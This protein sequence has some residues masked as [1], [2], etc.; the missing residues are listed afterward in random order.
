MKNLFTFLGLMAL[1]FFVSVSTGYGG[2]NSNL[3]SRSDAVENLTTTTT[4]GPNWYFQPT[5]PNHTLLIMPEASIYFGGASVQ[6]GDYIGVFYDSLGVLACAGY[7]QITLGIPNAI[8]VWGKESGVEN[9]FYTGEAFSFKAWDASTDTYYDMITVNYTPSGWLP[10]A[11]TFVNQGMSGIVSMFDQVVPAVSFTGLSSTYCESDA[12]VTLVGSPSGGTF[13]GPGITGNVFSPSQAG[14][15]SYAYVV[16]TYAPPSGYPNTYALN[17][18]IYETPVVSISGLDATYSVTAP[19]ETMVGD[20]AGGIFSGTGVTGSVFS[21]STAGV[22]THQISYLYTDNNGCPGVATETVQ[23]LDLPYVDFTGL[24]SNYCEDEGSVTLTGIPS[25]GYFSGTAV[26]GNIFFPAIAGDGNHSITY[27]YTDQYGISNSATHSTIIFEVPTVDLGPDKVICESNTDETYVVASWDITNS[28]LWSNG[29]TS[30]YIGVNIADTYIVTITDANGCTNSDDIVLTYKNS[31]LSI[32]GLASGYCF[33]ASPVTL[34]TSPS[35]GTLSGP[36]ISG[37]TFTAQDAGIG[38]HAVSYSGNFPSA[39]YSNYCL[40]TFTQQVEVYNVPPIGLPATTTYCT[41]GTVTLDPGTFQ[42]YAWNTGATTS[43]I[44]VSTPGNYSVSVTDASGCQNSGSVSVSEASLPTPDLGSDVTLCLGET[45]TLN[46]GSYSAYVWS[47]GET[48]SSI[49]VGVA[50]NYAVTVTDAN[51]CSGSDDMNLSYVTMNLTIGGLASDYCIDDGVVSLTGSPSGGVFSGPG[52]SGSTFDPSVAGAG[53]KEIVYSY[54]D[55]NNCSDQESVSTLVHDLPS[56]ILPA[57]ESYCAGGSVVLDPGAFQSYSWSTGETTQTITVSSVGTFSVTVSDAHGCQNSASVVVSE[58]ALPTPDLGPDQTICQGNSVT[59]DPGSFAIYHWISGETTSTI[60]VNTSGNYMVAVTDANGCTNTDNTNI[61]VASNPVVSFSGLAADYCANAAAAT[62][63]GVPSTGTFSGSGV[64][65]VNFDPSQAGTGQVLVTYTVIDANGCTGSDSQNTTVFAQPVIDFGNQNSFCEGDNLEL[66]GGTFSTYLW[67]TT[68]TSS[69]IFV[70]TADTYTLS[71]SDANGCINS[72][73]VVVTMNAAPTV[74]LGSDQD[75][76]EGQ[77]ISLSAGSY[78]SYLWS[79]TETTQSISA[80][81]SGNYALTVTDINGCVGADDMN[82]TVHANPVVSFTGLASAFCLNDVDATLSPTPTGG[83]FSGQGI[84]GS[85]FSP[86]NAGVGQWTITYTL[87]DNNGCSDTDTQNTEVYALPVIDFGNQT[88]FCEG[89]SL[90]LNGGVFTAYNWSNGASTQNIVV[91]AADTYSL[92]VTDGNG[93]QNSASVAVSTNTL[94]VVDLGVDQTICDGDSYP[95]DAGAFESYIWSTTETTQTIS[96]ST[97]ES[98]GVTVTDANGCEGSD[99]FVLALNPVYNTTDQATICDGDAYQFGT[100]TLTQAGIYT[101]VFTA[102][103]GCDSTVVLTLTVNPIYN[104]TDAAAICQ[105]DSYIFGTQTLTVGGIFTEVFQSVEGCD[106]TVVLTLTVNPVY[107]ESDQAEICEGDTYQFGT[108]ILSTA[109]SFTEV[110]QSVDGCDSTVTLTLTVNPIY[111]TTDEVT[112]CEGDTYQFGPHSLAVASTYS[113]TFQSVDGCDSTVTLTLNVNPVYSTTDAATIC[114]GDVFQFGTQTLSQAGTFTEVFQSADG[115]DSTVSLTLTVNPTYNTTNA[116]I[117]CDGDSYSFGTQILTQ[118][119]TYTE[120]FQTVEGC[121]STVILSLTVN[122][123][124]NTTDVAVIC[125]GGFYMFGGQMLTTAGTYTHTFQS[126]DGCDSTVTFTLI[127]NPTYNTTD[128]ATICEGDVFQFGT[129]SLTQAGNHT[130]VFQTVDGCDSTVTLTLTVHPVFNTTDAVSICAGDTYQFGNQSLSQGGIFTEVFQS[131]DGCDSTVTLTLTVNPVY[132]TTDAATI[133]AGDVYQFGTQTLSQV[134]TFTEVFQSAE[135][136][137]S[138]VTLTLNVNPTYHTTD[139]A[140]ICLGD[141][142]IFGTQM[143]TTSGMYTEVFQSME[144][145]DSTVTL[146]LTVNPVY[147]TSDAATICEGDVYQFGT[148]NLT[149]TGVFTEVFQSVDGCDSTVT[150]TLTVNPVFAIS[151]T[152]SICD[153]DVYVLGTQVISQSGVYAE[154]FQSVDGCDSTVTLN[155][156]VNPTYSTTDAL[157]I[158]AGNSYQF[159]TQTLNQTGVYT[160]VFT[161][162]DG[163]DSTVTLTLTVNPVYNTTDAATICEGD[164]FQFGTQGLTQAGVYTEVFP[165]VNGC[166]S[167]VTFTLTVNPVFN[168]T[169]SATICMGDIYLFGTQ[170][171]TAPGTYT[172][173]FQTVEGCDSTVVLTLMVNPVYSTNDALAVCEGDM[174]QFGTQ[175][176]TQAGTF[177]EVFQSAEGC[178]STVTLT[179]TVNPV[180]STT[181]QAEICEGDTYQFG[182]QTLSQSGTYTEVF[183]TVEGCDSTVVLTFTVNPLPVVDLGADLSICD[184]DSYVIDAGQFVSYAWSTFESTQSITVSNAGVYSIIVTDAN[185]C[186][187]MDEINIG[188]FPAPTVDLGA[189]MSV[190][191]GDAHTLDAG[192][193]S[194][195]AWSTQAI[196]Q[197][198]QIATAG[199]YSVTVTDSNGCQGSDEF[200]L[201]I[202]PLPQTALA[203]SYILSPGS[204]VQLDAGAGFA[205]Y[206]WNDNSTGQTLQAQSPGTYTVEVYDVNSCSIID[207]T[208]VEYFLDTIH[209]V[210]LPAGWSMFSTFVDPYNDTITNIFS[211]I[212]NNVLI[213]KN[214]L[215]HVYWPY[216]NL[217]LIG[218]YTIGQGYQVN[219]TIACTLPIAGQTV[220]PENTPVNIPV[221]WSM[222]GYLRTTPADA[223][224]MTSS[225]YNNILLMKN[226]LGQSMWPYF[227]LNMIGNMLPGQGY[228]INVDVASTLTYPANGSSSKA[229]DVASSSVSHFSQPANTGVNMTLGIPVSAWTAKPE[230][231]DEIAVLNTTGEVVGCS[232]FEGGDLAISIWGDDEM[233]DNPENLKEGE[234]F[235][236]V[237]WSGLNSQSSELE[238]TTWIEGDNRF[239]TNKISIV[240]SIKHVETSSSLEYESTSFPNPFT[241]RLQI[242]F[243][244]AEDADVQVKLI[245]NQGRLVEVICD[246]AYN[247]GS[248]SIDY[249]NQDLAPGIYYY[250][251]NS[252]ENSITKKIVKE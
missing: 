74:D 46:P 96:V 100:Q 21:P 120:V 124:Y 67:S 145:C 158:C 194:A 152:E 108:Q 54:T 26:I 211:P 187:G 14:P 125:L 207:S 189:D 246:Q 122:P 62:L 107:T 94:P 129:Q 51:G 241:D 29:A 32:D 196:T 233:T 101:E 161:T 221:G 56:L 118:T 218:E 202:Y 185:G 229:T 57:T 114:D 72:E 171:L 95:L 7:S 75:I 159:G 234:S 205:S 134:G 179:L 58:N 48:T 31:G 2:T 141:H 139:A 235:E 55:N 44:S 91:S 188:V 70:N 68:E 250:Q 162:V 97:A 37:N 84:A 23:V 8:A 11:G 13:S 127:V 237:I 112:I 215:G 217:N 15:T 193:F 247:A 166:D 69:S 242:S 183:Q 99:D 243:T 149:Q 208:I 173:V 153:G 213:V 137:D 18:T 198:V 132:S 73:S 115:C 248:H 225:I 210:D 19:D 223:E 131:Y 64:S 92:S 42:S 39:S 238:I 111:N 156:T 43:T 78:A 53:Q 148:Q 212:V 204:S 33:G 117:I 251:I 93:C 71:V 219:T 63:S 61:T 6:S 154:V 168:T 163:C 184:G 174:Y 130:E 20:P 133:C 169:E 191:D 4:T 59:L 181:D 16:Y 226:Y 85:V 165:T 106:S 236:L 143:L 102:Q 160:E 90:S 60:S 240:G 76:C 87:V 192:Q 186:Y 10:N 180:Y 103:N 201:G 40:E 157:S 12:D 52:V 17:T 140:E 3:D 176:L 244:I 150:L 227:N 50:G 25:G 65:G 190:C 105:G 123:V 89:E 28:Y 119:G 128:A 77:N 142:Y 81:T 110:F 86:S 113:N 182:T 216:F 199:V 200:N 177:T 231:G 66:N 1:C 35:G 79:T 170:M 146:S 82:L 80:S 83:T 34:T 239:A 178:D 230:I 175:T 5:E 195:Y 41:G 27:H 49:E 249:N 155:L 116:A 22:G 245:D 224:L 24:A 45:E 9:G 38:M 214:Y 220:I 197:T 172:E 206:L 88:S 209:E 109:G 167:S 104:E 147:T 164:V 203:I 144:G 30:N 136:C 47:T 135:G 228:Q 138:T 232:V 121:D 126:V 222:I 36:G 151:I 98:F 252:G